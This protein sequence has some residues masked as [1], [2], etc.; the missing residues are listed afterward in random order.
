[1]DRIIERVYTETEIKEYFDEMIRQSPN[2]VRAEHLK[3]VKHLM[4]ESIFE[5]NRLE[6]FKKA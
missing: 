4:F 3:A 6:N 2:S 1:M 5:K